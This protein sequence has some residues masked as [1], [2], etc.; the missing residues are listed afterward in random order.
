MNRLVMTNPRVAE[1]FGYLGHDRMLKRGTFLYA[2][3]LVGG[4]PIFLRITAHAD[5]Y[6]SAVPNIGAT[7]LTGMLSFLLLVFAA[8]LIGEL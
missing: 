4:L 6:G 8:H 1:T 2:L 7:L 5:R 3:W